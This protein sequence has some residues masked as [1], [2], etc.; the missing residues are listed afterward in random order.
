MIC[1]C[2]HEFC[3]PCL[4]PWTNNHYSCVEDKNSDFMDPN[5]SSCPKLSAI[6]MVLALPILVVLGLVLIGLSAVLSLGIGIGLGFYIIIYLM[7]DILLI[8]G[9]IIIPIVV[10]IVAIAFCGWA[11]FFYVLPILLQ[12]LGFYARNI[13][14]LWNRN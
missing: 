4:E 12:Y 10:P 6:L 8:C 2:K 14:N 1:R 3:F 13:R 9:V 5:R 7:F 11:T